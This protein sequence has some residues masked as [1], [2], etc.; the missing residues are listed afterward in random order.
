MI[1]DVNET[2]ITRQ[3]PRPR[4]YQ[5]LIFE[6]EIKDDRDLTSYAKAEAILHSIY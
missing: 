4:R 1:S 5:D 3:R 2:T 6:T